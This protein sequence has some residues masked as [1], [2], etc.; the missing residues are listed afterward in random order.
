[1]EISCTYSSRGANQA[2]PQETT[3][4]A[5]KRK[6]FIDG[7]KTTTKQVTILE[8]SWSSHKN[9]RCRKSERGEANQLS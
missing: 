1:M 9:A 3:S 5:G 2:S 4:T 6:R 7:K 8:E